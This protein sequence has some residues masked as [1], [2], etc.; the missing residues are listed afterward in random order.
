MGLDCTILESCIWI[1]GLGSIDGKYTNYAGTSWGNGDGSYVLVKRGSG[2]SGC[3]A[4]N[5]V[6]ASNCYPYRR[7]AYIGNIAAPVN[8]NDAVF[9]NRVHT[10]VQNLTP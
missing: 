6:A 8:N 4:V 7:W 1:S 10:S 2:W 9:Y 5:F 3:N